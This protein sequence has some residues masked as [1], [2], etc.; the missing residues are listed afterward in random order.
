LRWDHADSAVS[1]ETSTTTKSPTWRTPRG[2][3]DQGTNRSA[4]KHSATAPADHASDAPRLPKSVAFHRVRSRP[5]TSRPYA[6]RGCR[7]GSNTPPRG[8]RRRREL[9]PSRA[10]R[11]RLEL[12]RAR[13]RRHREASVRH[14]TRSHRRSPPQRPGQGPPEE[15]RAATFGGE[16]IS[17]MPEKRERDGPESAWFDR[18]EN[19]ED[20]R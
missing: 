13:P 1:K 5:G 8:V 18:F 14:A 3:R 12:R 16:P 11:S 7:N 19:G 17:P 4:T 9:L 15:R 10:R 20:Q 2:V 6:T